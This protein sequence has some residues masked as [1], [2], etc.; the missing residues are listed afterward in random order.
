MGFMLSVC[1]LISIAYMTHA[2]R[3][4]ESYETIETDQPVRV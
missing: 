3:T 4:R 1:V 2:R